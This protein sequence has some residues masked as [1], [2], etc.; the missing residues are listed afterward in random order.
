MDFIKKHYEKILLSVVLLGVIAALGALPVVIQRDNDARQADSNINNRKPKHLDP[1]DLSRQNS[2]FDRLQSPLDLD[3]AT[4][5]K[6]FNPVVWK[7]NPVS[8]E[9]I[10]ATTGHEVDASAAVVTNITPLY[11]VISLKNVDVETNAAVRYQLIVERQ[12]AATRNGRL[13]LPRV[14]TLNQKIKDVTPA[15]TITQVKGADPAAPE[16]VDLKLDDTG[17]TAVVTPAKPFKRPDDYAA[18]LTYDPE[19]KV[20]HAARVG[21]PLT[22]GGENYKIVAIT[23]NEVI[24]AAQSNSKKTI[25]HYAP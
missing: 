17:E 25:L 5:N 9:L 24:L 6:L 23:A 3:F 8:G 4:S 12:A 20:V 13:P 15:F 16:E 14:A 22:F 10:K 1:L 21:T 2:V 11:L 18:D 19:K 7:R